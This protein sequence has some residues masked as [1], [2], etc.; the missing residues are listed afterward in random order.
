MKFKN[1]ET[2][3]IF[4]TIEAARQ[5]YCRSFTVVGCVN[6]CCKLSKNIC[7][8]LRSCTKLCREQP[9]AAA[10]LM[11]YR[12]MEG[13]PPRENHANPTIEIFE[14]MNNTDAKADTGKPRPTLVPPSL[15]EAVTVVREYGTTKYGDPENWR[16]VEP[17]RYR[18]ALYRHWLA[19]LKGEMVDEESGLP[20]LYHMATNLAFLIELGDAEKNE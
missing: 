7:G 9:E 10:L 11:G 19:Y 14:Q 1:P 20:H 16:K 5:N 18:D 17:Q 8:S 12:V 15:V 4:D 2:G 3:E 13:D 6:G